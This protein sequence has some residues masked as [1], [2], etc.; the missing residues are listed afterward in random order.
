MA[1]QGWALNT[2]S[3]NKADNRSGKATRDRPPAAP[4]VRVDPKRKPG[5][6][7]RLR[8]MFS[9]RVLVLAV[10]VV[11][12]IPAVLGLLYRLEFIHPVST[13]MLA[14]WASLQGA[15][16]QWVEIDDVSPVLVHSVIMSED[17]QFCRHRGVDWAE[18]NAVISD[19]LDGEKTRGASTACC[20]VMEWSIRFTSTCATTEG[21]L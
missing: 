8:R 9:L 18:L 10:I 15:N 21:I 17:G 7:A 14:R 11:A 16:R 20:T 19:A 13:P 3:S 12:A 6:R 1:R 2:R 5:L 4:E